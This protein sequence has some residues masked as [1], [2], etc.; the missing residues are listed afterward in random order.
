MSRHVVVELDGD[1]LSAVC[2]D[3]KNDGI[4]LRRWHSAT[5][6]KDVD[7]TDEKALLAWAGAQLKAWKLG[8]AG[9]TFGVPRAEV[10]LKR[11]HL[12]GA[13][14]A[15]EADLAGIVALQMS[16]QLSLAMQDPV[17]DF[18]SLG[19]ESS[20]S[21][22]D[23][24]AAALPGSRL[25]W[26]RSLAKA[27]GLRL[28]RVALRAEGVAT[29]V[30]NGAPDEAGAVLGIGIGASTTEFVVVDDGELQ[31]ARAA[32]IAKG[33]SDP[34]VFAEQ[35][36]VEMKRTWMSYRMSS[37]SSD[38]ERVLVLGSR[39][40]SALVATRCARELDVD[41]TV[42]AQPEFVAATDDIGEEERLQALP[43]VG[44]LAQKLVGT[45]QLDFAHPRRVPDRSVAI[46]RRA[47]LAVLGAIVLAG[48]G[49]VLAE[50]ELHR[51]E[52]RKD[53]LQGQWNELRS[54]YAD[55]L[56]RDA[57]AAHAEN[58]VEAGADW[59][60]HIRWLSDAMPDP[61]DALV[62]QVRASLAASVTFRPRVT[63]SDGRRVVQ[64]S[65][66]TWSHAQSMAILIE[67][68]VRDRA[69]ADELR[70]KLI[71][72]GV[73]VVDTRGADAE[74][75]FSFQLTTT[76]PDPLHESA[77]DDIESQA[78]GSR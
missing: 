42:V 67:G 17:F 41:A 36:A 30:A 65:G 5:C 16:R 58:Y 60:S 37:D 32:E 21:S 45:S 63:E 7:A 15:S 40:V 8:N 62:D 49:Y 76:E 28:Q 26:L 69:T 44:L 39:E 22:R 38:V 11:L 19:G 59:I 53:H 77:A 31:F 78:E 1:R 29:L 48:I 13:G 57:R 47:M 20:G 52:R 54:E 64:Y 75:R 34:D 74:D 72:S 50:G 14:D 2:A 43:L 18:V 35:V 61:S 55:A 4:L 27:G 68:R 56:R 66:G 24:L 6:P 23:V 12:T 10:V 71:N 70:D 33:H 25:E 9:A 51:L 46:R 3:V 73:Y